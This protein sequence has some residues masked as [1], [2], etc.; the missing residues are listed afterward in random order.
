MK[1]ILASSSVN[2]KHL[3]E[4][5]G[6][7][8]LAITPSFEE[9]IKGDEPPDKQVQTF[10]LEKARSVFAKYKNEK[11][12]LVMGFDSMV[13]FL[14]KSIGK[15]KT[16]KEAFEMLQSFVGQPQFV[17]SGMSLVGNYKGQCFEKSCIQKT[18]IQFR[19]DITNCQIRN[20]LEFGDWK[21]KCGA[22]SILGTGIF[23]LEAI[24][25]D[26]QNIVGVP[27]QKMG[28]MI[29]KITGESPFS[30]LKTQKASL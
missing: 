8:F 6:I 17:V 30:I 18:T 3:F 10:A 16:K 19:S 7:N 20:Y 14:G 5:M 28:E 23:F 22:Y 2:R 21:G 25:G 26:F 13:S 9:V 27:V 12:V 15:P 29:R 11:E 24:T 4:K 1:I